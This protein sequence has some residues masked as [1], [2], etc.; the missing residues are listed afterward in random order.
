VVASKTG[1]VQSYL[2]DTMEPPKEI[3][4]GSF[5]TGQWDMLIAMCVIIA[6]F[7]FNEYQHYG[8]V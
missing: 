7:V 6:V 3:G 5:I 4:F 2:I 1:T 8:N